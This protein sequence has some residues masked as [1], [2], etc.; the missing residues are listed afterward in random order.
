[1][2][3]LGIN[4]KY[5]LTN[6]QLYNWIMN[7]NKAPQKQKYKIR[8]LHRL[9]LPNFQRRNNTCSSQTIPKNCRGRNLSIYLSFFFFLRKEHFWTHSTRP[10]KPWH[11]N[12]TNCH[13]H[14]HT[15]LQAISLM[16]ID[17]K[18]LNKILANWIQQY[19]EG[20]IHHIQVVFIPWMQR[21]IN[22]CKSTWYV[23]LADADKVCGKVKH[24]FIT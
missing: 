23:T 21:W 5:Q 19:S 13:T 9:I 22:I 12:Q 15:K 24:P 14:T 4:I 8:W 16:N 17:A 2:P 7:L 1:M 6:Y 11:Q 20:T 10:A 18:I 3:G